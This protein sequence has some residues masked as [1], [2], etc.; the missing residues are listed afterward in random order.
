MEDGRWKME[1]GS[2]FWYGAGQYIDT[3][4]SRTQGTPYISTVRRTVPHLR[5][6]EGPQVE[7][8]VPERCRHRCV[9]TYSTVPPYL[10]YLTNGPYRRYTV[11]PY[12]LGTVQM[13]ISYRYRYRCRY[14]YQY[15]RCKHPRY[16]YK[17][18]HRYRYLIGDR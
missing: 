3:W 1:D 18:Q 4:P 7:S 10:P 6:K 12:I 15:H 9:I 14:R 16:R 5:S 13:P 17:L 8:W 11:P 2:Q